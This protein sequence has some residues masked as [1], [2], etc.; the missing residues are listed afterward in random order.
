LAKVRGL[1]IPHALTIH[2]LGFQGNFWSYDFGL[3]NLPSSYFSPSG[4]EFYGSLNFLKS[5]LVF[6]DRVIFP[7]EILI[8]EA[9]EA[10]QGCGLEALLREHHH[11]L[12]GIPEA[13]E[14]GEWDPARDQNLAA[15]FSLTD[16]KGKRVCRDALLRECDLDPNPAGPVFGMVTRLLRNKGFDILLP[17]LDRLLA[18]N[19][20]LVILGQGEPEYEVHLQIAARKHAGKMALLKKTDEIMAR[21]IF[22]GADLL[23]AP[24]KLEEGG[25]RTMQAMRY[26]VVPIARASGGLRQLIE[27][28]DPATGAGT[29]FVFYDFSA[30]AL[31]DAVRRAE[32]IWQVTSAWQELV[33]RVM[34][35]DYSWD[36]SA[37]RHEKLYRSLCKI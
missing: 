3:T 25:V 32:E 14:P 4:V 17:A 5:G 10:G 2:D 30:D 21:K 22:A 28:Y 36:G 8:N 35:M 6:A 24:A 29:G 23:L 26:G 16:L 7:S 33:R 27:D 31:V 34:A 12:V 20:R 1:S 9:M 11:K 19:T 15:S 13:V 37:E 18:A